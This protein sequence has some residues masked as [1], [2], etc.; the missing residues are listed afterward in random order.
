VSYPQS[1]FRGC[2]KQLNFKVFGTKALVHLFGSGP[3][4]RKSDDDNPH[5]ITSYIKLMCG[6]DT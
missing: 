3:K 5:P 6:V 4:Y 1:A 2:S